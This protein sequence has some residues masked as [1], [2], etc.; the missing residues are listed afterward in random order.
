MTVDYWVVNSTYTWD[1]IGARFHHR[2]VAIHVFANG[3]GRHARLMTNALL[4]NQGQEAFTWG[5]K[6]NSTPIE[7]EEF[8]RRNNISSLKLADQGHFLDLIKFA[9][10]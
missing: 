10:S 8:V 5:M 7:V 2:L 9:R 3:N 1:E 6:S 4:E